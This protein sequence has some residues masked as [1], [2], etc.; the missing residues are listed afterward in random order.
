MELAKL[1]K[2]LTTAQ[3]IRKAYEAAETICDQIGTL[4]RCGHMYVTPPSKSQ[5]GG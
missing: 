2:D 3:H 1:Q 4:K 5:S